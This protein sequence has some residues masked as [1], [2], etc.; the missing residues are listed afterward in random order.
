MTWKSGFSSIFHVGITI[1]FPIDQL[2]CHTEFTNLSE[3]IGLLLS[4]SGQMYV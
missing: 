4:K 1:F 2:D 3:L